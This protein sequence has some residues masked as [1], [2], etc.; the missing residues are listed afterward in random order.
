MAL[1]DYACSKC[2]TRTELS[3]RISDRDEVATDVCPSCNEVGSLTRCVSSAAISYS[4]VTSG[5][6]RIDNGFRDV[7]KKIHAEAPGSRLNKTSSHPF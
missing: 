6:G 1:Y 7:L 4:A 5:Y 2:G 3:K